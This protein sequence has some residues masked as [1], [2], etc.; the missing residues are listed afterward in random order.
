MIPEMHFIDRQIH[1]VVASGIWQPSIALWQMA[2]W[3]IARCHINC[4]VLK[5]CCSTC[6]LPMLDKYMAI[7]F[8]SFVAYGSQVLHSGKWQNGRLPDAISLQSVY[9]LLINSSVA[10]VG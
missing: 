7:S 10:N 8:F 3:Q 5:D 6:K 2:E 4:K 9:K 1:N